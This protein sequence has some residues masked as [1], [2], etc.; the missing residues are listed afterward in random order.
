M[1]QPSDEIK[2]RLDIVDVLRDYIQLKAAG[3]N[4]RARCPFHREKTPSFMVSPEKQIWHCFGCGKGG[5]IFSF[6]QEIEGI[7]FLEALRMLAPKAGVTLKRQDPKIASQRNRLLDI[8]ELSRKYYHKVLLDSDKAKYA[9]EY[10]KDRG[11]AEEI[12][13]EWQIGYS[14]DGWENICGFL[15]QRGFNENEIFLAGMSIKSN[16]RPGFYDRFRDRIMFP[17]NDVNGSTVGFSAR[18]NPN[19]EAEEK[20]GKYINS[21]QTLIYDKS[22]ILFGLDK[23]KMEIKAK[24][25]AVLVEGQMDVITAHQN[26]YKNVVASSGTALTQEQV[27]LIKRYTNNFAFALDSD[28]AGQMAIDRG[29]NVVREQDRKFTNGEDS[30]GKNKRYLDTT[31][32]YNINRRVII[33]PDGMDPD[34]FIKSKPKEWENAVEKSIPMMQYHFDKALSSL[35]LDKIEDR[36]VAVQKLLPIISKIG[37]SIEQDYWLKVLSEKI[38]TKESLLRETLKS[39]SVKDFSQKDY[40]ED[41]KEKIENVRVLSREEKSSELLLAILLKFNSLVEYTLNQIQIDQVAGDENRLFYKNLI[42]YYNNIINDV[43]RDSSLVGS[44]ALINYKNYRNWLESESKNQKENNQLKLLDKLVILGDEEFYNF[45]EDQA[46]KELINITLYLK[47]NYLISRMREI[48]R[49]ISQSEKEKNVDE[50]KE[51]LEEFKVLSD[52]LKEISN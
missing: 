19:K 9:R 3:V 8:L 41:K 12:I 2:S 5:D 11:L 47:K 42:F 40:S 26:G 52:E 20:M 48:E 6:V 30:Q 49:L 29:E 27:N 31:A 39:I 50:T 4:F 38:D 1:L 32:S 35:D 22:K 23:A 37:N 45:Q 13:E 36:R 7:D 43:F 15:K 34:E 16:N 28:K 46:K 51:L 44:E 14:P 33:I 25:L 10:L 18:V 17:I 24:D 21:P